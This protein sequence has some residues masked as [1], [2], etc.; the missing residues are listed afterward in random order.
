METKVYLDSLS[1]TC[2]KALLGLLFIATGLAFGYAIYVKDGLSNYDFYTIPFLFILGGMIILCR[3]ILKRTVLK[4]DS[5]GITFSYLGSHKV[6]WSEIDTMRVV[7]LVHRNRRLNSPSTPT[8]LFTF[9]AV[10]LK[11][12]STYKLPRQRY[13][14]M[15]KHPAIKILGQEADAYIPTYKINSYGPKF[16]LQKPMFDQRN[17]N[18]I[19]V[20]NSAIEILKELEM[21]RVKYSN[22]KQDSI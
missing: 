7:T 12:G 14:R 15:R 21:L 1:E 6:P 17:I 9:L 5:S 18:K 4:T 10:F 22:G 16:K 20:E 3:A 13:W 2:G 8:F 19:E 11:P